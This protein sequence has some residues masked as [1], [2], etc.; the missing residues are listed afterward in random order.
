MTHKL[1]TGGRERLFVNLIVSSNGRKYEMQTH[2]SEAGSLT[3]CS[4]SFLEQISHKSFV[5]FD[6]VHK[7]MLVSVD[8]NLIMH[9]SKISFSEQS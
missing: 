3:R 4:T 7:S 1:E 2:K 6:N 9:F 5:Y 8:V